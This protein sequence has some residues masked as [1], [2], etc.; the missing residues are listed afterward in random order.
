MDWRLLATIALIGGDWVLRIGLS[1]RVVMRRRE[2]SASLAWLSL[3]FFVPFVGGVV[4]LLVGESRLG[5]SRA[6]RYQQVTKSL[7]EQGAGLWIQR[8]AWGGAAARFEQIARLGMAQTDLPPFRGNTID[9]FGR[10]GS[11]LGALCE[12]IDR[13]QDHCHVQTYIWQVGGGPDRVVEALERAAGRGVAC[14]VLVDSYGAKGFLRSDRARRLRG[15]GVEVL[16]ALPANPVRML[17]RRL[18]LRNHRKIVVI[19]GKIAYAG[20]QNMTDDAFRVSRRKHVGP[21]IDAT[22]RIEGV[23]AQA[24]GLV[25]LRDWQLDS[26]TDIDMTAFLPEIEIGEGAEAQVLPSG[27]G[28]APTAIRRAVLE[29]IHA[30]R[31]ELILTTPYFVPDEA[32][33]TALE[34]AAMRGV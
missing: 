30:A 21:W 14:R 24:L 19:D 1:L 16:G 23:A 34:S 13:A 10:S 20:S 3:I 26:G 7:F 33:K 31:E 9:L 17:F 6:A 28:G 5:A 29:M 27:P 8:R 11:F 25:F 18:D 4:Y 12:D 2:A 15:A 32:I 22:A